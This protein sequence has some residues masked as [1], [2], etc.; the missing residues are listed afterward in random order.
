MP[1]IGISHDFYEGENVR[2]PRFLAY[3]VENVLT[4]CP[5]TLTKGVNDATPRHRPA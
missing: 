5:V 1:Y 2:P 3:D 4:A